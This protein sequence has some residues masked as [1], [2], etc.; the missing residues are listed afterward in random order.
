MLFVLAAIVI[1]LVCF[2]GRGRPIVGTSHEHIPNDR[3]N[4]SKRDN[5]GFLPGPLYLLSNLPAWRMSNDVPPIAADGA[6]LVAQDGDIP[7]AG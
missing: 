4:V 3:I 5:C 2:R 6:T 7:Y 1:A